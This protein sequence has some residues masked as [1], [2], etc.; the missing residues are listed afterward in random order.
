M[1][2]GR[3]I[4]DVPSIKGMEESA[5]ATTACEFFKACLTTGNILIRSDAQADQ[6]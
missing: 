2:L 4:G 1:F 5:L 3:S 6:S